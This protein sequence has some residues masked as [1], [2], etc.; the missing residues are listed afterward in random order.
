MFSQAASLFEGIGFN[1][2]TLAIAV[3]GLAA[4]LGSAYYARKTLFPPRRRLRIGITEQGG[5][6]STH[7]ANHGFALTFN[8]ELVPQAQSV[9]VTVI[10]LGRHSITSE[11]FDR[12]RPIIVDLGAPILT[13]GESEPDQAIRISPD[14]ECHVLIGPELFEPGSEI[15]ALT[16]INGEP[17]PKLVSEFVVGTTIDLQDLSS[18]DELKTIPQWRSAAVVSLTGAVL[19][20]VL[21]ILANILT[22]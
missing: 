17:S 20:A 18:V 12:G 1:A 22:S 14:H 10:N 21:A 7:D 11:M 8:G 15:V 16:Y 3:G 9:G 13:I 19:S 4:G 2:A 6:V 5:A